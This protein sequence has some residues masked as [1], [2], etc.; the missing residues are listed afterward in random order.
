MEIEKGNILENY[1]RSKVNRPWGWRGHGG[2]AREGARHDSCT[3]G[4]LLWVM[5][6]SAEAESSGENQKLSEGLS[7]CPNGEVDEL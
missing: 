7:S 2:T 4:V 3:C 6:P 5:E 1:S